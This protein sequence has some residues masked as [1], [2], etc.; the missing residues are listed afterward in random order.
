MSL[1]ILEPVSTKDLLEELQKIDDQLHLLIPEAIQLKAERATMPR[2]ARA[3]SIEDDLKAF[4]DK[5]DTL[6]EQWEAKYAEIKTL[7]DRHTE[8]VRLLTKNMYQQ[9]REL[10]GV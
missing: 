3:L 9:M 2:Q 10:L 4:T 5:F 8:C 6:G 7:R 1:T